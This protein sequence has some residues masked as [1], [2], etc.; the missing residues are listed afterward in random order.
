MEL[1]ITEV[2][3]I[4]IYNGLQFHEEMYGYILNYAKNTNMY[5]DIYSDNDDQL[6]W[7]PLYSIYF[8]NFSIKPTNQYSPDN[9]YEYIFV[10]T[11]TDW[12]F[13]FE[14]FNLNV[15]VINHYYNE[16]RNPY[17]LNYINVAKFKN[18]TLDYCIPCYPI[19]K[20]SNKIQN[21][22]ISIIGG[23][24]IS[25][26]KNKYNYNLINRLRFSNN[27][28]IE[29]HIISR[30]IDTDALKEFDPNISIHLHAN[31]SC[32]E[33]DSILKNTSYIILS[34]CNSVS[35]REGENASGSIQ[36]AYNYL[37]QPIVSSYT[38]KFLNLKGSF[39]F[40]EN[41]NNPIILPDVNFFQLEKYRESYVNYLPIALTNLKRNLLIPKKI[42]QTWVTKELSIQFQQIVDSWKFYNPNYEYI[43][44]DNNDI[45]NFIKAH[46]DLTIL[47]AYKK[48]IP[49]AYKADLFRYCYL[50]IKGGIY[51]DI[52]T[53]CLGKLDQFILPNI[54]FIAPIDLNNNPIDGT[55]NI[56]NSFIASRPKHPIFMNCINIIVDNVKNKKNSKSKLDFSGPGVLGQAIN[57]YLGN[58]ELSSFINKEGIINDILFLKFEALTEEVKDISG[59]I[60]FQNKNGNPLIHKLYSLECEKINNFVSWVSCE[61][62]INEEITNIKSIALL[63]YGQFRTYKNNLRQNIISLWPIFENKIVYVFILSDKNIQ[64][65]YSSNNEKEILDI[66]NEFNFNVQFLYYIE[67]IINTDEKIYCDNFYQIIKNNDEISNNFVPNLMYRKYLLNKLACDYIKFNK[68]TIDVFLYARLFD[69]KISYIKNIKGCYVDFD[70]IKNYIYYLLEDKNN[71]IGSSDAL[72][73]GSQEGI[74]NLFNNWNESGEIQ[75]FHDEVWNDIEFTKY[76]YSC[77]SFLTTHRHIYSP[78]IQYLARVYYSKFKYFNIRLDNNNPVNLSSYMVYNIIHD[79]DRLDFKDKILYLDF[80]QETIEK[81]INNFTNN[82]KIIYLY[83]RSVLTDLLLILSYQ[84]NYS[85]IT[86]IG[87]INLL[88]TSYLLHFNDSNKNNIFY[89]FNDNHNNSNHIKNNNNLKVCSENIFNEE[90]RQKYNRFLLTSKIIFI[91]I[92]KNNI[93][94][95][96]HLF[97]WL[98]KNSFFGLIIYKNNSEDNILPVEITS[99]KINFNTINDDTIGLLKF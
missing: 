54:S 13:K 38:N 19:S 48:I 65:N 42:M 67:D 6:S 41:D 26:Y 76:A 5:V 14:W 10:T 75:I 97:E 20:A 29:L 18:S 9:Q 77:N 70:K 35:K 98:Y 89:S 36:L 50:Y 40:N 96:L 59:N 61:N 87:A 46:F 64:G 17:A 80:S 22:S 15:I 63:I 94:D 27:K 7:Y 2:K 55:H 21:N 95:I 62:I 53:L 58:N 91:N 31:I 84:L 68:L 12:N 52:D 39:E 73:M 99:H 32:I 3:K 93:Q 83:N 66:F 28:P 85:N 69:M 16:N 74:Q 45:E 23:Y 11:D 79:P 25:M 51:A 78:E 56:F 34:S 4:A 82:N 57:K 24:E 86:I 37:C 71:I 90:E 81:A 72:F 88:E 44:F 49:G 8:K 1:I 60:L 92:N 47:N 30:S 43:L 33:M